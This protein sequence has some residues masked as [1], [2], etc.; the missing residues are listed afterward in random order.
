LDISNDRL[1]A[2]PDFH[3]FDADDLAAKLHDLD[4]E[5][6]GQRVAHPQEALKDWSNLTSWAVL[7]PQS[8]AWVKD[9]RIGGR[10]YLGIEIGRHI[11]E[12]SRRSCAKSKPLARMRLERYQHS[13]G[14]RE[15]GFSPIRID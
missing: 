8:P 7:L 11:D 4:R 10:G 6:F 1:T 9:S 12:F 2:I 14:S 3:S 5:V 15:L 13:E